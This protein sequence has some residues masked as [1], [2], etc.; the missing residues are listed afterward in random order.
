MNESAVRPG[1]GTATAPAP[2]PSGPRS[3]GLRRLVDLA[4]EYVYRLASSTLAT[5]KVAV[6]VSLA[7]IAID[8]KSVV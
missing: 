5:P 4:T 3:K 2:S 6:G 8:R 7:G 1:G